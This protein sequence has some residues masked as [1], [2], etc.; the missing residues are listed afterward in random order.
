MEHNLY[1][2]VVVIEELDRTDLVENRIGMIVS[3]VVRGDW[4][5]SVPFQSQDATLQKN[6]VFFGQ[7][8]VW[9]RQ[10]TIFSVCRQEISRCWMGAMIHE[11]IRT[12]SMVEKP[13]TNSILDLCNGVSE[14]LRDSLTL[15]GI[16]SI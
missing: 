4:R 14:L 12:D 10:C 2:I 15:Q 1:T 5:E 3:H 6:V 16:D 8:L 11:P 9:T 13:S 7:K